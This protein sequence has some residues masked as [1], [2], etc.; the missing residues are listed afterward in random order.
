MIY[1]T[2]TVQEILNN[3]ND[4]HKDQ[5][6]VYQGCKNKLCFC[7]GECKKIVGWRPKSNPIW[8]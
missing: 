6:P 8:S 1:N 7:T 5:E 4:E 3:W 2:K